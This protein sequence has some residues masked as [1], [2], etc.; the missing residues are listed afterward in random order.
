[1]VTRFRSSG[2]EGKPHS[3]KEGRSAEAQRAYMRKFGPRPPRRKRLSPTDKYKEIKVSNT[4]TGLSKGRKKFQHGGRTNLYE[5]LGRVE[6]EPSNRNRRAEIS[7]VH[8][9][10]NRGYAEGGPTGKQSLQDKIRR[11]TPKAWKRKNPYEALGGGEEGKPH[12]T[13]KGRIASGKRRIKRI[14]EG[15]HRPKPKTSRPKP[16]PSPGRPLRPKPSWPK[17]AEKARGG[18]AG[19]GP[20]P[21]TR[22]KARKARAAE[23]WTG[24]EGTQAVY[25]P[26]L[27][28]K[29][30]EKRPHS[31]PEGRMRDVKAAYAKAAEEHKRIK[32]SGIKRTWGKPGTRK[33]GG[34]A[35]TAQR[36]K[37]AVGGAAKIIPK[38][39]KRFLDFIKTG[40]HVD[41]HGVKV[42]VPKAAERLTGK[43]HVDHGIRKR[44]KESK[45]AFKSAKGKAAGGRIGLKHGG[46]QSHYLQH[47]YGPTK[48]KLRTGKPK[49]AIKGW[50]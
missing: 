33:Y 40:K 48:T 28:K 9:E 34:G 17:R 24:R 27:D 25:N 20:S 26:T 42:N 2:P 22:I 8:G 44:N 21:G 7:R 1:M 16:L 13:A 23:W 37:H 49:I 36:A 32:D 12:S 29:L 31:S 6:A 41:K 50:S 11:T 4:Q 5:E 18:K 47:G 39:T 19:T 10:L 43:P 35:K 15:A 3:T 14:L 45:K 46:P 30:R 38:I